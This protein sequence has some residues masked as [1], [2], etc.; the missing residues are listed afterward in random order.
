MTETAGQFGA[1]PYN[2]VLHATARGT[3]LYLSALSP[4]GTATA[5]DDVSGRYYNGGVTELR[6]TCHDLAK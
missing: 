6:L 3:T 5:R 4:Q 1:F 2:F